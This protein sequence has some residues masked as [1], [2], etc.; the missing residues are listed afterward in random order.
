MVAA[1]VAAGAFGER[2]PGRG[3]GRRRRHCSP[4]PRTECSSPGTSPAPRASAGRTAARV[5]GG[6]RTGS[7]WSTP[8]GS[9]WRRRGRRPARVRLRETSPRCSSTP[10]PVARSTGSRSAPEW[11]SSNSGSSVAVSPDRRLVAVT[12]GFGTAIVDTRTRELVHRVE[13]P[14][15]EPSP[16]AGHGGVVQCLDARRLAPSAVRRGGRE[17]PTGAPRRGRHRDLAT[18]RQGRPPRGGPGPGVVA[19]PLGARRRTLSRRRVR[20]LD[21][22][23]DVVRTRASATRPFDLA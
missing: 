18:G 3:V 6:S 10:G 15:D 5:T 12:H 20:F 13:L 14:I 16:A 23:L 22:D 9:W 21:R 8:G 1:G 4:C 2:G 11:S 19:G 7:R 17:R